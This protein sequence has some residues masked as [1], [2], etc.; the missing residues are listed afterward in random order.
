MFFPRVTRYMKRRGMVVIGSFDW[1][2]SYLSAMP[3]PYPRDRHP[4]SIDLKEAEDFGRELAE[5]C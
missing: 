3:K 1:Y 4:D 5:R 2:G